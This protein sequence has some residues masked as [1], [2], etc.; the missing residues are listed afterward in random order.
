M[1][2]DMGVFAQ[3]RWTLGRLTATMGV[4]Y[5]YFGV[6]FPE[7]HLGP[8]LLVPTRELTFPEQS[9]LNWKDINPRLGAAYDLF[10]TGKTAVRVTLGRYQDS[11]GARV[12]VAIEPNPI[13]RLVLNTARAW[14][15]ANRDF[16]P[17]CDL[18][19]PAA[20]GECGPMANANF[21][22]QIP[23]ATYDPDVLTGWGH[24]P[25]NWEFSTGVQQE[26]L[27]RVSVDVGYFRRWWGNFIVTDNRSVGPSD[28]D[29][30]SITAPR[31]PRLPD[32]GG[33]TIG[34]LYDLK[35][36]KFGV[37]ANDFVTHADRYGKQIRHWNGVDVTANARLQG[38]LVFGGGLSTG[39][40]LTDNCNVVAQLD[41]PSSRFC[42]VET[43]FLTQVKMFS[44]FT[45]PGVDVEVSG[46]FQSLP[47]QEILAN[48]NAP[49]A[50]VAP[51]LGRNLAGNAANVTVNLV[52]PGTMY[53]E[54]WNQL[55]VRLGK[56]FRVG[57]RSRTTIN[58]DVY[59][60]LNA[61]PVLAVNNAFAAWQRP[62]SIL[63]ARFLRLG[64]QVDF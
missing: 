34:G 48:Y 51:S 5:S 13:N 8:G 47:S 60:V 22:K 64:A 59:N 20:N 30:F 62:T 9:N 21:G 14:N 46:V 45:V 28:Y 15:D 11:M 27:P 2:H 31:D 10:G 4:R 37:P 26:I 42:H 43:P 41:N 38:R 53:G 32:G 29:P 36:A 54:R 52:E 39:R 61:N 40:T 56:I 35:P 25:V 6:S 23:G 3:D 58:I 57:R 44:T 1:D 19:N 17:A 33:Y 63:T 16:V 24:R 55:D 18:L 12:G 50:V 7:Q 49:N